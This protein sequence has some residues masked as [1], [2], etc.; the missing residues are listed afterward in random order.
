MQDFGGLCKSPYYN[1]GECG[2]GLECKENPF[3][4]RYGAPGVCHPKEGKITVSILR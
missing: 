1:A 2:E 3:Q 4:D